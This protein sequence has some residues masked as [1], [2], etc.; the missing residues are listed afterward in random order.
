MVVRYNSLLPAYMCKTVVGV[1]AVLMV[2]GDA[3]CEENQV[4][5]YTVKKLQ[6]L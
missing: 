2:E 4:S 3:E 6:D 5:L 1:V